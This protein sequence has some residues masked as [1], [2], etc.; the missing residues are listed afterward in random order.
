MSHARPDLDG[1]KVVPL[2]D[3][4][5]ATIARDEGTGWVFL[6]IAHTAAGGDFTLQIPARQ[7]SD[8]AVALVDAANGL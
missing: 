3:G 5:T 8:L 7:A 1:P 6:S 4:V 2:D